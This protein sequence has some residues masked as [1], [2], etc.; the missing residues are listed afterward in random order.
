MKVGDI[1]RVEINGMTHDGNGVGRTDG[2]VVFVTGAV[3]GDMVEVRVT[4][5]KKNFSNGVVHKIISPSCDRT[6]PD[7]RIF[8]QCGGCDFRNVNYDAE[9]RYKTVRVRNAFRKIAG[10]KDVEVKTCIP[11]N[12][13]SFY[14]NKS[15]F[16]V[17]RLRDGFVALGFLGSGSYKL[18]E[19]NE[20]MVQ[21][22]VINK[23]LNAV[24]E[25]LSMGLVDVAS[26]ESVNKKS[27]IGVHHVIIRTSHVNEE[28]MIVFISSSKDFLGFKKLAKILSEKMDE[29]KSVYY[30]CSPNDTWNFYTGARLLCGKET[31]EDRIGDVTVKI[32]PESFFQVNTKQ[33]EVLYQNVA[34]LA[35]LGKDDVVLDVYC[36]AGSISLYLA[37]KCR[38]VVGI[39][40]VEKT[41]EDAKE[42]AVIND[43]SN[44]EFRCG[45]A[46]DEMSVVAGDGIKADVVV[47]DPPRMGCDR[48]VLESIASIGPERIVYVS[49][50]PETLARDVKVLIQKGYKL[51]E[52]QPVDMFPGTAHVETVALLSHKKPDSY[53]HID[54]EFGEGEGKISLDHIA[55]RAAEH[56]PKERVNYKMMKEYI[57]AKYGF[58]VHTAYIAEVKRDLGLPMYDTPNAVEELKQPKKHPTPEKVEA[59]KDALKHFEVI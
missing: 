44:V 9:L 41:I 22:E 58:K 27:D 43:I 13:R 38:K 21:P 56:K 6:D 47:L 49:C 18:V 4:S 23:A 32:S 53:I 20:C 8:G 39:E 35:D 11:C 17:C 57:E 24:K 7:C 16:S 25:V 55:K 15:E 36:G 30:V 51:D 48:S 10:I 40:V 37:D 12:T 42:N 5:C 28:A 34:R 46:E 26:D 3:E 29:I 59:I 45:R 52:V 33:A 2:M 14:R 31:I 19:V 50:D 54:V 1:V